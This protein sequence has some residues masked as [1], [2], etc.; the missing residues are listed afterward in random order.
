MD[1][2]SFPEYRGHGMNVGTFSIESLIVHDVPRRL[3]R[4]EPGE[5][6]LLS[7]VPSALDAGLR[8]FF[9]ERMKRSLS[10]NH[11]EVERDPETTSPVPDLVIDLLAADVEN[12]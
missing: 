12:A 9:T 3:A 6:L 11:Y 1:K 5:A 10:R 7:E 4:A 8:N 2:P